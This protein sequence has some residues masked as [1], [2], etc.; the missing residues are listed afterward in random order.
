MML[1]FMQYVFDDFQRVIGRA[2]NSNDHDLADLRAL[3]LPIAVF[4]IPRQNQDAFLL[5]VADSRGRNAGFGR[6]LPDSQLFSAHGHRQRQALGFQNADGP[7]REDFILADWPAPRL[8]SRALHPALSPALDHYLLC[9]VY[10]EAGKHGSYAF[11]VCGM[12]LRIHPVSVR[13]TLCRRDNAPFF[14]M[15]ERTCGN[16]QF[17]GYINRSDTHDGPLTSC[18][19]LFEYFFWGLYHEEQPNE[20]LAGK[21]AYIIVMLIL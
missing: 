12:L 15:L 6:N 4:P 11:E 7:L 16:P 10:T 5:P 21:L 3:E 1:E 2:K 14:I 9:N 18:K 17:L 19:D 20:K 13:G 8:Q